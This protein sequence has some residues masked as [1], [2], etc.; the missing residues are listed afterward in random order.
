[1]NLW[2]FKLYVICQTFPHSLQLAYHPIICEFS[3]C[4]FYDKSFHIH[5]SAYGNFQRENFSGL[6]PWNPYALRI[7]KKREKPCRNTTSRTPFSPLPYLSWTLWTWGFTWHLQIYGIPF[8]KGANRDSPTRFL[9][10]LFECFW[11]FFGVKSHCMS[12]ICT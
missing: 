2:I 4:G 11:W 6:V 3:N 12:L 9:S 7:R 8:K 10:D 1:M 5:R